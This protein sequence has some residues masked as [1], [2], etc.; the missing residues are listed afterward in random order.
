MAV[1][2]PRA[3]LNKA[4]GLSI[5]LT[6]PMPSDEPLALYLPDKAEPILY[7]PNYTCGGMSMKGGWVRPG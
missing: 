2:L 5:P 3:A 7:A 6:F 4:T 1:S